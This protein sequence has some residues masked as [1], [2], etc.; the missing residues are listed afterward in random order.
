[1]ARSDPTPL[2]L[3]LIFIIWITN[4]KVE[5]ELCNGVKNNFAETKTSFDNCVAKIGL[6]TD[7][8]IQCQEHYVTMHQLYGE[9]DSLKEN[10][11]CSNISDELKTIEEDQKVWWKIGCQRSGW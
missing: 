5:N 11:N 10:K 1:M 8:C 7:A 6:N 3:F 4:T 2:I 9:L